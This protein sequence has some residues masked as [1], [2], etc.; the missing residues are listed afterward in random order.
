MTTYK[1]VGTT[2]NISTDS[3][4]LCAPLLFQ[5]R[6]EIELDDN[7][8]QLSFYSMLDGDTVLVRW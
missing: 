7:L 3:E 5:V 6:H 1:S 8:R 4:N 2:V